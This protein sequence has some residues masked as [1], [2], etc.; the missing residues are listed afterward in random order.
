M[1][2]CRQFSRRLTDA[3]VNSGNVD[4]QLPVLRLKIERTLQVGQRPFRATE[5]QMRPSSQGPR[6]RGFGIASN[7]FVG[8][9]DRRFKRIRR[10]SHLPRAHGQRPIGGVRL[11]CQINLRHCLFIGTAMPK[12]LREKPPAFRVRRR[13]F[14]RVPQEL[15][16]LLPPTG[17]SGHSALL[18]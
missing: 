16:R 13:F 8:T 9:Q 5:L 10:K 3:L 7:G 14:D 17:L 15:L 1:P 4:Q 18:G 6:G 2:Q 11:E 12:G